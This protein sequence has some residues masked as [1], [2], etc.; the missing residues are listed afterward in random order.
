MAKRRG[1]V[2]DMWVF[3]HDTDDIG[4]YGDDIAVLNAP[5][6]VLILRF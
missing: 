2:L 4:R 5:D 3:V 1:P 6:M